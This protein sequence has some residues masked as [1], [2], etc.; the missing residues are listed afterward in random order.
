MKNFFLLLLGVIIGAVTVYF[1]FCKADFV[2]AIVEPKGLI[3]PAEARVLDKA[4]NSRHRLISDSIV[5]RP[6]NRSTWYSL[7]DMHNYLNYAENEAKDLGYTMN[8]V[9]VYLGAYPDTT[10]ENGYTTMFFIPT[11][12]LMGEAK[13]SMNPYNFAS[14]SN[15]LDI[16]GGY[17][18]NDGQQ[19]NPPSA[20]YP[21]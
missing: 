19:G 11:G 20:N 9:R 8:G 15:Y 4:F 16:P 13:A 18:L 1:F 10:T 2:D 12:T 14:T 5:R 6:D 21:Q 3:T 7:D 17:G